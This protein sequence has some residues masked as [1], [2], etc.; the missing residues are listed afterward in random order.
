MRRAGCRSRRSSLSVVWAGRPGAGDRLTTAARP[1]RTAPSWRCDQLAARAGATS[2]PR[3]A[4]RPGPRVRDRRDRGRTATSTSCSRRWRDLTINDLT[5]RR[6]DPAR[7]AACCAIWLRH[8]QPPPPPEV[9]PAQAVCTRSRATRRPSPT[10]TTCPTR[11][12]SGCSARRWPT[13][14]RSTR[15]RRRRWRRRRRPSTTWSPASSRWSPGMR[16]LD[17]GCGWGGMVMHAAREYGVKALG[18][19]LS[20]NAG[21]VGAEG[22]RRA[23]GSAGWPRCA[24][25]LPRRAG[26]RLRRDQ[27]DRPH[28]AHRQ[29]QPARP[30]SR[31]A[32]AGCART[33]GCSTTASPSRRHDRR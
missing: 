12:T 32:R 1:D 24:T 21:R 18:V 27:L 7:C 8:H 20:R 4:P 10:T 16:L 19:T 11:S 28:R 26:A 17:V 9:P 3:R 31:P 22:D 25:G 15:R 5:A 30:T 13:P 6:P 23:P 29:G 33:A 14:A 2:P